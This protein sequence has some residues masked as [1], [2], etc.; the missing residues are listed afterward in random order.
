MRNTVLVILLTLFTGVLFAQN[1]E[2]TIKTS[3]QCEMCKKTIEDKLNYTKGIKFAELNVATKELTVK[4]NSSKIS[5]KEIRSTVAGIGYHADDVKRDE[6][7]HS[8]LPGCCKSEQTEKKSCCSS[9]KSCK[10]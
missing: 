1:K 6:T 3:A 10:K 7:A 9:K 5:D 2:I 4:Y 8:K